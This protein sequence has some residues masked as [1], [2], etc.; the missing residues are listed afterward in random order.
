MN[1]TFIAQSGHTLFVKEISF[2]DLPDFI[3]NG[4][5]KTYNKF[6]IV[7]NW[8]DDGVVF[9]YLGKGNSY[10]PREIVVWYRNG[11]FWS[12]YGLTI[13][14]AINGAQRDGWMHA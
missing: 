8:D 3:K 2:D 5:G 10:A 12:S 1:K 11:G 6:H 9:M 14:E 4:N 13:E 7:K